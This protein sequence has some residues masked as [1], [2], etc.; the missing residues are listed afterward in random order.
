MTK[1]DLVVE[2]AVPFRFF[3]TF[4]SRWSNIAIDRPVTGRVR[5]V[6]PR[7]EVCG[8]LV[9]GGV[10]KSSNWHRRRF[11]NICAFYA[12][13][14]LSTCRSVARGVCIE[15]D[16]RLSAPYSTPSR[17]NFR[18]R[19]PMNTSIIHFDIA[20]PDEE[21]LRSTTGRVC[22]ASNRTHQPSCPTSLR[23]TRTTTASS[24]SPSTRNTPSAYGNGAP[25]NT[26]IPLRMASPLRP[27][28]GTPDRGYPVQGRVGRYQKSQRSGTKHAAA[29]G[30]SQKHGTK[31]GESAH[32]QPTVTNMTAEYP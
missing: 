3:A 7:S 13:P 31:R 26:S 12:R 21:R 18:E 23:T 6:R 4:V 25:D 24:A 11:R 29:Q 20:G 32:K 22:P 1:P 28:A 27:N 16:Q 8:L 30:V 15:P 2:L 10:E 5:I 14:N 19:T 17:P 9:L